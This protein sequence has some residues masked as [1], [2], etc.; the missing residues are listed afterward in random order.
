M[1][2]AQTK[3]SEWW[4][5]WGCY[6]RPMACLC[7]THL[8]MANTNA[9]LPETLNI[10]LAI[11]F[12]IYPIISTTFK[13]ITKF[14]PIIQGNSEGINTFTQIDIPFL[15]AIIDW[16]GN[17]IIPSIIVITTHI[18]KKKLR[19]LFLFILITHHPSNIEILY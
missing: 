10:S 1:C 7:P 17:L 19:S 6:E 14:A 8:D 9:L 15:A 13:S 11:G 3:H 12:I 5:K 18:G 4:K 2:S 16:F